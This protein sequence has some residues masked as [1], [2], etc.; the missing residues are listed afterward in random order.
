MFH[1]QP[2]PHGAIS[3]IHTYNLRTNTVGG[4]TPL[5]MGMAFKNND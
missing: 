2:L 5:G 3:T 4:K 1:I